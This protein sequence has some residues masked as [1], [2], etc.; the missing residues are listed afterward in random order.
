M[1]RLRQKANCRQ[2]VPSRGLHRP[3]C[4]R[5]TRDCDRDD[6]RALRRSLGTTHCYGAWLPAAPARDAPACSTPVRG[7]STRRSRKSPYTN[8]SALRVPTPTRAAL[9]RRR[10]DVFLP[11]TRNAARVSGSGH[12][13]CS[14]RPRAQAD[15]WALPVSVVVSRRQRYRAR[16]EPRQFATNSSGSPWPSTPRSRGS[17]SRR[18]TRRGGLL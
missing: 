5:G 6:P 17:A 4:A 2:G 14:T 1:R 18:Q 11:R 7:H 16:R 9:A 10:R 3:G 13:S 8:G 12:S 15:T